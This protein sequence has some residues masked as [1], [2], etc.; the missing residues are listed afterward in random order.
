MTLYGI[1]LTGEEY[2]WGNIPDD[3]DK[4]RII[5]N[6]LVYGT[7]SGVVDAKKDHGLSVESDISMARYLG[8]ESVAGLAREGRL[9][10]YSRKE[11]MKQINHLSCHVKTQKLS[12]FYKITKKLVKNT[13][14]KTPLIYG[15][16]M[17]DTV[18]LFDKDVEVYRFNETPLMIC[19]D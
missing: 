11:I 2:F 18:N 12:S 17:R 1:Y 6:S 16:I 14:K 10:S 19:S 8:G 5:K 4:E 9:G 7:L 13:Y 15:H 3:P